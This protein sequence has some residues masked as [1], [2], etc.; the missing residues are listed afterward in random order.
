MIKEDGGGFVSDGRHRTVPCLPAP[1]DAAASR[2]PPGG[3]WLRRKAET[4][5]ACGTL[6]DRAVF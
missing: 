3:S 4:E 1:K 6:N 2:L 5:G